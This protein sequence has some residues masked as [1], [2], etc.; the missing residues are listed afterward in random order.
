MRSTRGSVASGLCL[1]VCLAPLLSGAKW[2]G[3]LSGDEQLRLLLGEL[4]A[5]RECS[6]DCEAA[7]MCGT[8][9]HKIIAGTNVVGPEHACLI[10]SMGCSYHQSCSGDGDEDLDQLQE[11]LAITDLGALAAI[12]TDGLGLHVN[13]ER[14]TIQ[15]IGCDGLVTAS[16]P[17]SGRQE[18]QLRSGTY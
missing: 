8:A 6:Y 7:G 5:R 3:H 11:L 18:A 16:I 2:S 10:T 9:G 4:I 14:G 12:E 1:V 15:V 17:L 13:R